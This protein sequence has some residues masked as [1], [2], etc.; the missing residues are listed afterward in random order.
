MLRAAKGKAAGVVVLQGSAVTY[1]FVEQ[2]LP[3]I[4]KAACSS[5]ST[6]SRRPSCSIG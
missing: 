4:D 3:L 1:A 6:A 2:A 5:T